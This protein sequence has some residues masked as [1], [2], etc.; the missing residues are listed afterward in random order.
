MDEK[1][2]PLC[3][4]ERSRCTSRVRE[5]QGQL[6]LTLS[7]YVEKIIKRM[8]NILK[9]AELWQTEQGHWRCRFRRNSS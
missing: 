6:A 8:E 4:E 9:E 1:K 5:E 3:H 2:K 7:E